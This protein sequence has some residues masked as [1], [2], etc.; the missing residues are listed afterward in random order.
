MMHS[1]VQALY[2]FNIRM[3]CM[4]GIYGITDLVTD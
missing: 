3:K 4:Y 2:M 1:D